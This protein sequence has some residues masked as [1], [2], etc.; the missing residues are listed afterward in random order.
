MIMIKVIVYVSTFLSSCCL[1]FGLAQQP[2]YS[3]APDTPILS[4]TSNDINPDDSKAIGTPY[5]NDSFEEG[6]VIIN[7]K[8]QLTE[9]M[10]YNAYRNEIEV[11]DKKSSDSYY[12]LLKRAYISVKIGNVPYTIYTYKDSNGSVR[13]SYFSTLNQ[14]SLQ[15]L[16]KPEAILRQGRK[17]TTSYEKYVQ[18]K[19]VWNNSYYILDNGKESESRHAIKVKLKKNSILDFTGGRKE[20][21]KKYIKDQNLNLRREEDVISFLNYFNGKSM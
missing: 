10:R 5:I 13:T 14:G 3:S 15:L 9:K 6:D 7:N 20:E 21:M 16:F 1:Q 18:P 17:P 19:Y 2:A 8:V 11:L 4:F 12:S